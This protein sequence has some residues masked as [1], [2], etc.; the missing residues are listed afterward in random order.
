MRKREIELG[1]QF[2]QLKVIDVDEPVIDKSGRKHETFLCECTCGATKVVR[3]GYLLKGEVKSCGCRQRNVA[4]KSTQEIVKIG[5]RF[6]KLEVVDYQPNKISETNEKRTYRQVLCKCDCG[7][8]KVISVYSLLHGVTRSCGC[9]RKKV[10]SDR[11]KREN[12]YEIDG[13][14]TKVF[15]DKGNFTLIDTK[16]L[17]KIRPYYFSKSSKDLYWQRSEYPRPLHR[18]LTD[19]PRDMVVDHI[20]HN[21][22][23]NR[24]DNLKIC[25]QQDNR[26]N[27]PFIGIVFLEHINKWQASIKDKAGIKYIGTF[28]T[29]DEAVEKYR[30]WLF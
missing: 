5:Q 25:T 19:C 28:N 21:R 4:P 20:N 26:K 27:Q 12:T 8:T 16:D 17:E 7:N 29:F 13:E 9:L 18:F 15:D 22:S 6:G 14:V 30:G 24:R 3:K 10:T 11:M 23:D 1:E 2:Y